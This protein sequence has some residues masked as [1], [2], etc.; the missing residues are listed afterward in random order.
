MLRTYGHAKFDA[1]IWA[2]PYKRNW[3]ST[4]NRKKLL[5]LLKITKNDPF[6]FVRFSVF[7]D[8]HANGTYISTRLPIQKNRNWHAEESRL[9]IYGHA[10]ECGVIAYV[11]IVLLGQN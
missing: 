8:W 3:I 1:G 2:C 9:R 6:P 11:C 7:L 10:R 5:K 4:E